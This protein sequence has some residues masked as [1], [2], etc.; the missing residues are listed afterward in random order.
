MSRWKSP[1]RELRLQNKYSIMN[2]V[3]YW[4]AF[5]GFLL[6]VLA[7]MFMIIAV[8]ALIKVSVVVN[9]IAI[10]ITTVVAAVVAHGCLI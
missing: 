8:H 9:V 4:M 7:W 3:V 1:P 5:S 10:R 2:C 6:N